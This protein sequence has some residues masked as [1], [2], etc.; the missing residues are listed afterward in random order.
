MRKLTFREAHALHLL[1]G[2]IIEIDAVGEESLL[3]LLEENGYL[4]QRD[5]H[6]MESELCFYLERGEIGS[7]EEFHD[8]ITAPSTPNLVTCQDCLDGIQSDGS[9]CEMC[10]GSSL[11]SE[12][13][14]GS[15]E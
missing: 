14:P 7:P 13:E 2:A 4:P 15:E 1:L 9:K 11:V 10:A 6:E 3:V 5:L 8:M 12:G